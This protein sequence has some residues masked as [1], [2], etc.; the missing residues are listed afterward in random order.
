MSVNGITRINISKQVRALVWLHWMNLALTALCCL[1]LAGILKNLLETRF[2]EPGSVI[3]SFVF[4]C[5]AALLCFA[6]Y[7]GWRHQNVID[8]T[9]FRAYSFVFPLLLVFC[10][11]SIFLTFGINSSDDENPLLPLAY[12]PTWIASA[13]LIGWISQLGAARVLVSNDDWQSRILHWMRDAEL[14]IM[15]SGK[16]H[17]VTWELEKIIE[18]ECVTRLILMI[19]EIWAWRSSKRSEEISV[20]LVQIQSVFKDTAWEEKLRQIDDPSALRAVLFRPDGSI[21]IIKSRSGSR[22]GYYLAALV[23]HYILIKQTR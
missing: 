21:I 4:L 11:L 3:G 18:N 23:A 14:I 5:F 9:L 2:D 10:S 8:P 6:A 20:R 12:I 1:L 16:T 17:W 13:S 7:T 22:E 19:P 15:Y